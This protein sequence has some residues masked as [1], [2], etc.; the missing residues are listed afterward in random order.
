MTKEQIYQTLKERFQEV[1]KAAGLENEPV[2]VVCR[3]LSPEEAIGSTK[4]KDYPILTGKD[5]MIQAECRGCKGQAFTDAPASFRGTLAEVLALDIVGDPHSRSLFIAVL[6][7]VMRSLGRC[8]DTVHCR[9]DGP[10]KCACDV[11]A[12]LRAEWPGVKK[13]TL[14]GY[15]PALLQMLTDSGYHVR[16]MDLNPQNVGQLRCGVTVEDGRT[17][18]ADAVRH[19]E[20]ILCTGS[21]LSNGTITDYLELDKPVLF[22]GITAAGA[23]AL[24]GL[25]RLCFADRYPG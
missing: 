8:G 18:M 16:V 11:K 22:F 2:E 21:T 15:Q 6:N 5:V 17:A 4:R 25:K 9:T 20:L 23:A 1:L 12:Y 14:V 10:E 3:S 13:I 7:A 19:A 24:L